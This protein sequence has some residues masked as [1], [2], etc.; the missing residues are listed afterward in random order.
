[1]VV[2]EIDDLP[3]LRR[4]QRDIPPKTATLFL[5]V[6]AALFFLI[7]ALIQGAFVFPTRSDVQFEIVLLSVVSTGIGFTALIAGLSVLGPVRTAII[8]TVEPFF[9]ALLGVLVLKDSLRVATL[10][11]GILIILAVLLIEWSSSTQRDEL[12]LT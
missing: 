7:A 3:V 6:G 8:A 11:G 2:D 1:M 9:T 12:S 10:I 5:V 4:I